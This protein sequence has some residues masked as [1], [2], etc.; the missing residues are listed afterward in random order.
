[1][2]RLPPPR[3]RRIALKGRGLR[4]F[5]SSFGKTIRPYVKSLANNLSPL[6]SEGLK[7][8]GSSLVR[9]GGEILTQLAKRRGQGKGRGRGGI[10]PESDINSLSLE[11]QL[12][13]NEPNVRP[14]SI[15][16]IANRKKKKNK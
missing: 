8:V 1:M 10:S 3:P 9:E 11:N 13:P 15:N 2:N 7:R 14:S 6:A 12:I 16:K 5:L 4:Q